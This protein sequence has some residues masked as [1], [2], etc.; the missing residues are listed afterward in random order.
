MS[1]PEVRSHL[2]GFININKREIAICAPF[3]QVAPALL[4]MLSHHWFWC[5]L[6][7]KLDVISALLLLCGVL[8]C[9]LKWR[10]D[11]NIYCVPTSSGYQTVTH[12]I[13]YTVNQLICLVCSCQV[14]QLFTFSTFYHQDRWRMNKRMT[15]GHQNTTKMN[16]APT[17][18]EF[19]FNNCVMACKKNW[20]N[21]DKIVKCSVFFHSW[22]ASLL[23]HKP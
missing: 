23:F 6:M 17:Q 19:F 20:W 18:N 4:C 15:H 10:L 14:R 11:L 7:R 1:F 8:P 9:H 12:L 5:S 21:F 22:Y 3:K 13:A 16:V 2:F